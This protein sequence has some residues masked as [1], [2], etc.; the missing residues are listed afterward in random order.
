M[1]AVDALM[2]REE[3]EF[4]TEDLLH[5]YCIVRPRRNPETYMYDGNHCV[6]LRKPN[7]P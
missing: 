3:K 6:R 2:R 1:L 7:Q 5:M 4:T